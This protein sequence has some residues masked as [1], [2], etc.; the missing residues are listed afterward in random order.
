MPSSRW[1]MLP[2]RG[3][4]ILLLRC[5]PA[6]SEVSLTSSFARK[7]CLRIHGATVLSGGLMGGLT[8]WLEFTS[9]RSRSHPLHLMGLHGAFAPEGITIS[10][11]RFVW[12]PCS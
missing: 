7:H 8:P 4:V 6:R 11:A 1:A 5:L 3:G 9:N 12:A 2:G 10:L